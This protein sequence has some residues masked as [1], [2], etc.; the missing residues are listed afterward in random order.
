MRHFLAMI[1]V[2]AAVSVVFGCIGRDA[3]RER[4]LYGLRVFGEF[5][6][7]GLGLSWI[8]YWLPR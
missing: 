4:V 1:F 2:A 5:V 7:V 3:R 8:L 6:V